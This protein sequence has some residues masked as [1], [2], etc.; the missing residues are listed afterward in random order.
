MMRN[1]ERSYG[2]VAIGL[3]RKSLWGIKWGYAMAVFHLL[4]FPI[5]TAAGFIMLISLMGAMS[6]FDIPRRKRRKLVRKAQKRRA[7]HRKAHSTAH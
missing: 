5:G 2:L 1:T 3:L 6:E 7:K 4:I